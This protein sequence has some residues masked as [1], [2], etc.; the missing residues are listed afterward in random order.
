V[1][2][3]YLAFLVIGP[4]ALYQARSQLNGG[5]YVVAALCTS[6]LLL[7]FIYMVGISANNDTGANDAG[8]HT[9]VDSIFL[10]LAFYMVRMLI[11]FARLAR[12]RYDTLDVTPFQVAS[13][14]SNVMRKTRS[15]VLWIH[16]GSDE[17]CDCVD[18]AQALK[19]PCVSR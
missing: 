15:S 7:L 8:A 3:G 18:V 12:T 19:A 16:I 9:F 11:D 2:T 4:L 5:A 6:L 17:S 13:E 10:L 14:V 1:G